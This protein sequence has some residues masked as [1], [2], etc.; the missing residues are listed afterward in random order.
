MP[1]DCQS[2]LWSA[3][4]KASFKVELF[5]Y[6]KELRGVPKHDSLTVVGAQE[7]LEETT[8]LSWLTCG[9]TSQHIADVIRLL[10][11]DTRGGGWMLDGGALWLC[12]LARCLRNLATYSTSCMLSGVCPLRMI[13]SGSGA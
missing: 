4:T 6:S 11:V 5:T 1:V 2:G 12:P 9:A 13:P 3:L 8:A 10:A 7:L